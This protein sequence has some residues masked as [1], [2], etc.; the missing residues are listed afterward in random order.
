M[1][2]YVQ[3][4]ACVFCDS[5][6]PISPMSAG[7]PVCRT[8]SFASGLTPLY[9][10]ERLRH[11]SPDAPSLGRE[12]GVWRHRPLLPVRERRHEVTLGEG[13]TPLVPLP[14]I[15]DELNA[16]KVWIKDESRNPTWTFKDRN[17]AVT[18]SM[19]VEFGAET[20]VVSTSGNHGA[21]VAAYAA[22][23]GLGC[24]ALTYPGIP[25]TTSTLIEAFGARLVVTEP[26]ERWAVM[27]RGIRD[28]GWYPASN[29]TD[30]PT[31]GAY[32]HEG[33]KTI[34]YEIAESLDQAPD[35]VSVPTA[36]GEGL[37][38]IWKGFDELVQLG[39]ASHVPRMVACEPTGGPLSSA[40]NDGA[41][42]IV[43]VPRSPAAPRGIGGSVN[44][45]ISVAAIRS[46]RGMVS[47]SGHADVA[48]AQ[49]T[50]AAEGFFVEPASATAL[51]GL[52]ALAADGR[53]PP[54][55][56]IVIINTSAGVKNLEAYLAHERDADLIPRA[57]GTGR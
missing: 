35:V 42:P 38:G 25:E 37:F 50:L 23:A 22:R 8:E 47:Q 19:A 9:D 30:I 31:N 21:A 45:Y 53:L 2:A 32:G 12:P 28:E 5:R 29:F 3:E 18:V 17:A 57:A 11:D 24:V 39:K 6:F 1:S 7:C 51:A 27:E 46:S 13:G 10:Y 48:A 41:G 55:R 54:G 44:S 16:E 26:D 40:V 49:R 4:L 14:R 43:R 52:R 20:V 15:A 36:Y 34:A 33:Y 56:R